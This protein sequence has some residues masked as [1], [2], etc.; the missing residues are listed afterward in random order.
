M[1]KTLVRVLLESLKFRKRGGRAGRSLGLL[2]TVFLAVFLAAATAAAEAPGLRPL[3]LQLAWKHQFQFAGYYAAEREGF[4]QAAGFTVALREGSSRRLPVAE[5]LSGA[6]AYGVARSDL[7]LQR[8]NGQ[9]L[10]A[11][12]AVF[13]HSAIAFLARRDAGINSPQDM[14]GRRVMLLPGQ[15]AAEYLAV[16]RSEGIDPARINIIPSSFDI[17]DLISGRTEVFNA[18]LTNEPYTLAERGIAATIIRPLTYGIDFYGDTLFTSRNRVKQNEDE[19]RRFRAACL[20]G[21]DYAM[22][23]PEKIIDY[24][25]EHYQVNK[26]REHLRF[27]AESMRALILPELVEIGHMNPGRWRHMAET[28]VDLDM[29]RS[30][31]DLDDFIY[32]PAAGFDRQRLWHYFWIFLLS[33]GGAAVALLFFFNVRLKQQVEERTLDLR[34]SRDLWEQTFNSISDLVVLIDLDFKIIRANLAT[35]KV[36]EVPLTELLGSHCFAVLAAAENRCAGCPV[37]LRGEFKGS[38]PEGESAFA[39]RG[40]SYLVSC[41]PVADGNGRV[42]H[43]A[44][45]ARDVTE[46]RRLEN[47][48]HQAQKLEA[49][50]TLAGG[51]AHDFNNILTVILSCAE[52]ARESQPRGS[53]SFTDL[54]EIIEAAQ[55]AAALVRQILTFSRKSPLHRRPLQAH[56]LLEDSLRMLRR[57]LPST[58][59]IRPRIRLCADIE[60]DPTQF[61]QIVIN[62]CTNALHALDKEQGVISVEL[63]EKDFAAAELAGEPE[64]KPGRF[65]CLRV[66]DTGCGIDAA[67]L[68]HVFEP[69]FTTKEVGRGSGLGLAVVHGIIKSHQGFIRVVSRP[70]EGTSFTVAFPV[71]RDGAVVPSRSRPAATGLPGGTEHILLVDD[72]PTI[73]RAYSK[74]LEQLGYRVTA[75]SSSPEALQI[76]R[77]DPTTFALLLTDQ[78]MPGLSGEELSRQVLALRPELPVILSSG[79]SAVLSPAAVQALG[80]RK[81]A[82]K[83]LGRVALARLVREVLDGGTSVA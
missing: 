35:V 16:F 73:V 23:H 6:A 25:L 9:P 67:T 2:P 32:S 1:G 20:Q 10:V 63:D 13:Q 3:V 8:L 43:L 60:A 77:R 44:Y 36:F 59:E 52:V 70:G 55:R 21:W 82:A 12:A 19:V 18:Y 40:R 38:A 30:G 81:F 74:V 7:L 66:S 41:T 14:V 22:R 54:T 42:D 64:V 24:L 69:Y 75:T 76:F 31:Y 45:V 47:R 4:F 34:R 39:K 53:E 50:G 5:V 57:S 78:S 49:V 56:Q 83:P 33:F 15:H 51:V 72:E 28:Y 71:A 48:L 80:V 61:Q 65:V 68:E 46:S 29:A 79:Y 17:E 62:L 27:E 26:S 58:V 11:L 37:N